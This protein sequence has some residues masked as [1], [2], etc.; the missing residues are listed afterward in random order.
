MTGDLTRPPRLACLHRAAALL[1]AL[2]LC[3]ASAS[4]QESARVE[5]HLERDAIWEGE[6]VG[7]QVDV[8]DGEASEPDLSA[9]SDFTVEPAGSQQVN[10]S[11]VAI[12][13]GRMRRVERH[14]VEY[15]YRLTPKR[16]GRLTVPAPTVKSADATVRGNALALEVRPPPEQSLVRVV[17]QL[18]PPRC[19]PQQAVRLSVRLC[20]R[21][22][23][24]DGSSRDP[25][26]LIHQVA[27][28]P[29]PMVQLP[30]LELDASLAAPP[31]HEWLGPLQ[32]QG[33][34]G[35]AIND[36]QPR[37][38][39]L[40]LF[41]FEASY[42]LFDP[43]S[44]PPRDEELAQLPA[45]S[46]AADWVVYEFTREF[47][48]RATGRHE[49]AAASLKARVVE[50]IAN[51]RAQ[52]ADVFAR[53]DAVALTVL[54][55]PAEGRPA[56]WKDAIGRFTLEAAIA[57]HEAQV[58]DPLTL[59]L[60]VRGDGNLDELTP[61]DLAARPEVTSA[62]RLHPATASME[63]G[64]RLFT[65][66][67]RALAPTVAA[68]PPIDYA[69]FD[70]EQGRYVEQR[71]PPLPL[72]I[73]AAE[74]LDPAAI[75][76]GPAAAAPLAAQG[77][78]LFAPP[79]DPS[80]LA[81]PPLRW[82]TV[83]A[84]AGALPLLLL[85]VVG[86]RVAWQ[87]RRADPRAV[88]RAQ[89]GARAL[90]RLAALPTAGDPRPL[91]RERRGALLGLVADATDRNEAALTA[92]EAEA[93]LR[94][95]GVDAALAERLRA[96]LEAWEAQAYAPGAQGTLE[97]IDAAAL[98]RGV[99]AALARRNESRPPRALALLLA[100]ALQGALLL[101]P[102]GCQR[103]VDGAT[104]QR[105]V[106]GHELLAKATRPEEFRA[107]AARFEEA[108][109]SG[110]DEG[111]VL[112]ALGNAW[113][114]AGSKGAAIVAWRRAEF[115]RPRD[116]LLAANLAQARV[117]LP[118]E[119]PALLDELLFWRALL[120]YGEQAALLLGAVAVAC[121]AALLAQLRPR[122]RAV[123]RPLARAAALVALLAAIGFARTVAHLEW[124]GHAAI[125]RDGVVAR[126][127][128][129]ESF[130]AAL[131]APLADGTECRIVEARHD[132]R[133]I[134]LPGDLRG[135]VPAD[136]LATR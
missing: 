59:T 96:A 102:S 78:G 10:S 6:S 104:L 105:F 87:R 26:G 75:V 56:G 111:V 8:L 29:P 42:Y 31:W 125:A 60:R 113:F 20:V 49:F 68:V 24:G 37:G 129:G 76:A 33:S 38:G 27:A 30:W 128:D 13:N 69:W 44:R 119:P 80:L 130:E 110:G 66:S 32:A 36:L 21:R 86:A 92:R 108:L 106:E 3:C 4:A 118:S 40:S 126:K 46:S 2:L 47:K 45:G 61:P 7:Y 23:G 17:Q 85:L 109:A 18:D 62:F 65:W 89:A 107:A 48:P 58:G 81:G 97:A 95:A 63:S 135:W 34:R 132:W 39:G 99:A 9:F 114:A 116:P 67:V 121:A 94:A 28:D 79:S 53:S 51:R 103:A 88:R 122:S 115:H 74:G 52:L 12:E 57:P 71:T 124:S 84:I 15:R 83:A 82:T 123:M 127:G 91:A 14:G 98:A 136:A 25:I 120:G 100:A 134:E 5:C 43:G 101:A 77:S 133:L 117:G 55:P 93:A 19:Y 16:S 1:A 22:P 73:R 11:S 70:P 131:S 90:A 35:F 54:P 64:S 112:Q 50:R 41:S 72:S